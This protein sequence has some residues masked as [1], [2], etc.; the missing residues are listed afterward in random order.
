MFYAVADEDEEGGFLLLTPKGMG[1]VGEGEG[2]HPLKTELF[3]RENLTN[4]GWSLNAEE[5]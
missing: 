4:G 3:E 2:I 1:D 5:L